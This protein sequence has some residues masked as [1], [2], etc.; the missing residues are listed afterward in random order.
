MLLEGKTVPD[1]LL[2]QDGR[3]GGALPCK[4]VLVSTP[5]ALVPLAAAEV[6]GGATRA[7]SAEVDGVR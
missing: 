4:D 2:A 6:L 7:R 1:C 5:Q 3:D